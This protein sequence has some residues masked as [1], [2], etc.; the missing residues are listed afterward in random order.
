LSPEAI[1]TLTVE[2]LDLGPDVKAI[3]LALV[4]A[5]DQEPVS[6]AEAAQIWSRAFGAL[7][8]EEPW[9]L[10]FFSHLERIEE[11]CRTHGI[12]AR[13]TAAGGLAVTESDPEV[14]AQLFER[15]ER[16]TFGARAGAPVASGDAELE[17]ELRRRG[18][19]AYHQAYP[20]YF[21]CAICE[22]ETGSVTLVS[23]GLWASE[24]ARR[25]RPALRSLPVSVEMLM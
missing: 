20:R 10:D 19:D 8:G 6:G 15:F 17:G 11:F 5:G 24:V 2:A 25:L 3:G 4:D 22:L 16:E 7:A 14:L 1:L 12:A 13:E 23:E 18:I 9:V 21:Y